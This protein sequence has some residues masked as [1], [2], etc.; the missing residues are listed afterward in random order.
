M[1]RSKAY[2]LSGLEFLVVDDNEHMRLIVEQALRALGVKQLAGATDAV[3]AFQLMR[4]NPADIVICDINMAPLDGIEFTRMVRNDA[5]SPNIFVPIIILTGNSE[6]QAVCAARDA[7]AN[8]FLAKPVSVRSLYKR[9]AMIIERP[10]P[11]VR[12]SD[13]FGPDRRRRKGTSWTGTERRQQADEQCGV[14]A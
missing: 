5:D 8:E 4:T 12:S 9:I 1:N 3:E 7:G 10:R 14:A 13:Y 11:F 6:K 2:G